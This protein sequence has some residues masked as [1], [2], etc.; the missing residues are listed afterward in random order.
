MKSQPMVFSWRTLGVILI[1]LALSLVLGVSQV[2]S[3]H[4]QDANVAHVILF[5]SPS[6]PHCRYVVNE[7][8]PPLQAQYGDQLDVRLYNLQEPEG[9]GAYQALLAAWPDA[10]TGIPQA[11]VSNHV[12]VGSDQ[13]PNELPGIIDGCL[14]DGGCD[15]PFTIEAAGDM[16]TVSNQVNEQTQSTDNMVVVGALFGFAVIVTGLVYI[17]FMR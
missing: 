12:L 1:L 15:W 7:V 3:V 17:R 4:A 10:P 11:Y 9:A 6:C 8:L 13:I 2:Q 5:H 16:A 14:A